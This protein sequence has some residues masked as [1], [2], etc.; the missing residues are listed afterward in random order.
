MI[1][2]GRPPPVSARDEHERAERLQGLV[3]VRPRRSR[4]GVDEGATPVSQLEVA[5]ERM[6]EQALQAA[7]ARSGGGQVRP[8]ATRVHA[9][10]PREQLQTGT[11]GLLTRTASAFAPPAT[12]ANEARRDAL[13]RTN[14]AEGEIPTCGICLADPCKPGEREVSTTPCGHVFCVQCLATAIA[15]K[16]VCPLCRGPVPPAE[17]PAAPL[18]APPL[19][20]PEAEWYAAQHR[21]HE[22]DEAREAITI[23]RQAICVYV[24]THMVGVIPMVVFCY[25]Y[26]TTVAEFR[27]DTTL[28]DSCMTS[29]DARDFSRNETQLLVDFNAGQEW[30]VGVENDEGDDCGFGDVDCLEE[31]QE[32]V[33]E[34]WSDLLQFVHV[35]RTIHVIDAPGMRGVQCRGSPSLGRNGVCCMV[36][37][38]SKIRL[39][40]AKI[41]MH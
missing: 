21:R 40:Y 35:S 22:A 26:L 32:W 38:I 1:S 7:D 4:S 29:F 11:L 2:E 17:Q 13:R 36:P 10:P 8:A 27:A 5:R 20:G 39:L 37:A 34:R 12:P 14:T 15:I 3:S 41:L 23:R 24:C 9:A 30:P 33:A 19:T 25:F 18:P 6:L 16:P 28:Y 31:H